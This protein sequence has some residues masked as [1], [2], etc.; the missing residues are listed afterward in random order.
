MKQPLPELKMPL[1]SC[2]PGVRFSG[3]H[4]GTPRASPHRAQRAKISS[5]DAPS[6][7]GLPPFFRLGLGRPTQIGHSRCQPMQRSL[8]MRH[9]AYVGMLKGEDWNADW[10]ERKNLLRLT[11]ANQFSKG[12]SIFIDNYSSRA[13]SYILMSPIHAVFTPSVSRCQIL[14]NC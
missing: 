10:G 6:S 12:D 4:A 14:I 8:K 3:R 9:E 1:V 11:L 7:N 2:A 13:E 5:K